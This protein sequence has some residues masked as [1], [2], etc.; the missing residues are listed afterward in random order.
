MGEPIDINI[1][2]VEEEGKCPVLRVCCATCAL[3][4]MSGPPSARR[5]LYDWHVV[6]NPYREFCSDR[7]SPSDIEADKV[8]AK[9]REEIRKIENGETY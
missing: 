8:I 1:V 3:S 7:Y 9:W 2:R 4:A 5:C 6:A